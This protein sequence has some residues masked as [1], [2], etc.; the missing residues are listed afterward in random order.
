VSNELLQ[1]TDGVCG[2]GAT[3]VVSAVNCTLA[4]GDYIVLEGTN[5]SGKSTLLKTLLGYL[6]ALKGSITWQISPSEVGYVPQDIFLDLSAPASAMDVVLTAF[7]FGGRGVR[8]SARKALHTAG[9]GDKANH[10]FGTLS[11]GQRRRVLFARALAPQPSCFILDEPTVNMDQ[12]T[13][14]DMGIL[15]HRLVTQQNRAVIATSHVTEWISQAR[16]WEIR[17]GVFHG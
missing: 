9:I 7:P 5:G 15:L 8:E 11:G 14:A 3:P 1:V 6:P 4:R 2:Y 12:K 10:R 17:E 16:R 13:E